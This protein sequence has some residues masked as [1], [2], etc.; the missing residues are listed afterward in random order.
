MGEIILRNYQE[1]CINIINDLIPDNETILIQA[2]TGAGKTIIFSAL[3]GRLI[4]KFPH[5]RIVII[6]HLQQIVRQNIK[7]MGNF[8]EERRIGTACASISTNIDTNRRLIV[9]SIQTLSSRCDE[10]LKTDLLIIDEVHRLPPKNVNSQYK[11]LIDNLIEKNNELRIIGFTATPYRLKSGNIYGDDLCWFKNLSYKISINK[12]QKDNFLCNYKAKHI[13]DIKSELSTIKVS[14]DYNVKQLSELMCG[15]KHLKSI[16]YAI[17]DYAKLREHII[18]FCVNINHAEKVHEKLKSLKINSAV[19]HS[20]MSKQQQKII[21]DMFESG[22]T[23]VLCVIGMLSEGADIPIIDCIIMARPTKSVSLYVQMIGRGLRIE[24][25]KKDL[26]ILDLSN[27]CITHGDPNDPIVVNKNSKIKSEAP[28][29]VCPKCFSVVAMLCKKC[30]ECEHL[31]KSY[32]DNESIGNNRYNLKEVNFNKFHEEL[33]VNV[34][35]TQHDIY[36]SKAG[37]TM[38]K[39]TFHCRSDSGAEVTVNEFFDFEGEGSLY[40]KRKA[41]NIWKNIVQTKIPETV[42]EADTRWGEFIMSI[43]NYLKVKKD[44]GWWHIDW[45]I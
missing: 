39:A 12:L 13:H 29:K 28:V 2:A 43:P 26:L 38:L 18:V 5:I 23:Q 41:R 24:Q 27:N 10:L 20:N 6:T 37:N 42:C 8:V 35:F 7:K 4:N 40:G 16:V 31:F 14:G 32:T 25:N 15:V 1:K 17:N 36:T 9:G 30:P 44:N 33:I 34:K 45:I 22:R 3:V 19:L 11:K 21:L